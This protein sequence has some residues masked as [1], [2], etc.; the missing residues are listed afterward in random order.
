MIAMTKIEPINRITSTLVCPILSLFR[1][2][3]IFI[4]IILLINA[5]HIISDCTDVLSCIQSACIIAKV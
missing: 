5:A 2:L 1:C 4:I 3:S